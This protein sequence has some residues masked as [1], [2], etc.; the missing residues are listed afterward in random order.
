MYKA[1]VLTVS[2]RSYRKEREDGSGPEAI[3]ILTQS[4]YVISGYEILPDEENMLSEKLGEIADSGSTDVVFTLG[5]T[6]FSERDVTPEATLKVVTKLVPGISE[7]LRK[8][9]GHAILSR[10]VSGIYKK[11]LIINL[12]GSPRAV[13]ESLNSIKEIIK[14]GLDVL[15][16]CVMDC[17]K[18]TKI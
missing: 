12:P 4:G 9:G 1:F 15:S 13:R 14:H 17:G 10:G 8:N 3:D 5:G 6:G 2:D 16:G 18:E 11:T 7:Y